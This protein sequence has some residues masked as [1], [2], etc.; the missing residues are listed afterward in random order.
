MTGALTGLMLC[1]FFRKIHLRD[2]LKVLILMSVAFLLLETETRLKTMLPFSGLL[3]V[4][5]MG[6]AIYSR[7]TILAER[8]SQKFSR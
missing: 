3:A 4:M 6:I 2:S 5:A 8:L 1:W 7:Y